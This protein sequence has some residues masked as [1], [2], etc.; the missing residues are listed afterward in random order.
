MSNNKKQSALMRIAKTS[1]NNIVD[2][3]KKRYFSKNAKSN[4][5]NIAKDLMF[6]K[7]II[8]VEGKHIETVS[9]ATVTVASSLVSALTAPATGSDSNQ[10]NGRSI[11]IKRIDVNMT[12]TMTSG[13][14]ATSSNGNQRFQWYL[15]Q[16]L[17]TPSA[18]GASPFAIADFLDQDQAS[19]YT[20]M[21]LPDPDTAQDFKVLA[22]GL[23]D[24]PVLTVPATNTAFTKFVDLSVD[25]DFHQSFNS[26]TA[27]SIVE[28]NICLVFTAQHSANTG[29]SST[30]A[31]NARVWFIDN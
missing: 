7:S 26:T 6:L 12:F 29:G 21:S 25:C 24:V 11:R 22:T 28:N 23:V 20:P 4:V 15:V 9:N 2:A 14:A 17:D 31:Y 19:N 8:N 30:I 10:R 5:S 3:G 13:T 27:A 16:Y 18:S 1:A